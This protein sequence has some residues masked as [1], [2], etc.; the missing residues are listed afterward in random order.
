MPK[1]VNSKGDRYAQNMCIT[2]SGVDFDGEEGHL[3]SPGHIINIMNTKGTSQDPTA[4]MFYSE[5]SN[6]SD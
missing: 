5:T 4:I 1:S 6:I 2:A 3:I